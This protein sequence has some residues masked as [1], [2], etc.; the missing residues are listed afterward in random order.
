MNQP[1]KEITIYDIAKKLNLSAATVSRGLKDH[2]G[3]NINTKKR[4]LEAAAEMG[5]SSNSFASNL[6]SKRSNIIGVIV[7]RLNSIFMSDVIAGMEQVVND[8]GYTLIIGQSLESVQKEA[9][10]ARAMFS[11]RVDGLLVSLSYDTTSIAHLEP[12]IK[13]NIPVIFFDR[14]FEHKQCPNIHID[15]FKAGYEITQHLA[16]QGCKRIMHVS[17]PHQKHVYADRL[18]GYKAAL[19]DNGLAFTDELL[20]ANDL[21]AKAGVETAHHIVNMA[22][23]P[24]GVFVSNDACAVA[25]M[26]TLKKAGIKIPEDIAVAGFNND[27]IACVIEPNLTTIDYKGYEMGEVA[28][29]VLIGHL[30]NNYD[31]LLTHS[32]ILRHELVVR[33]STRKIN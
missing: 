19:A 5:Y 24:D 17:A 16:Q 30:V 6:R 3:I 27:P 11:N 28:A 2:P 9:K 14:V 21:S 15:N 18:N 1:D 32:L 12:F 13:R 22:E 26:Q 4:I 31:L 7:P 8:A 29:R 10:N 33:D 25:C 23:R 20:L